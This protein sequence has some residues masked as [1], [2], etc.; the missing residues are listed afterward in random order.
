MVHRHTGHRGAEGVCLGI[1]EVEGGYF[2]H[3][4][5]AEGSERLPGF[6]LLTYQV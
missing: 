5:G 2:R 4:A 3:G 6:R 1:T